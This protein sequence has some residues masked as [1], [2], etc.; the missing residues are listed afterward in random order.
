REIMT[1]G[2]TVSSPQISNLST[3]LYVLLKKDKDLGKG[4]SPLTIQYITSIFSSVDILNETFKLNESSP[5]ESSN[6]DKV[7]IG[8]VYCTIFEPGFE[9]AAKALNSSL[10][11]LVQKLASISLNKRPKN[12]IKPIL[13]CLL[14]P[15]ICFIKDFSGDEIFPQLCRIICLLSCSEHKTLVK[16]LTSVPTAGWSLPNNLDISFKDEF[17]IDSVQSL[18]NNKAALP[19]SHY[20]SLLKN[21]AEFSIGKDDDKISMDEDSDIDDCTHSLSDDSEDDS[22]Y[23]LHSECNNDFILEADRSIQDRTNQ[24]DPGPEDNF[25][26]AYISSSVEKL[27]NIKKS[28]KAKKSLVQQA[29]SNFS[30]S[31]QTTVLNF[32]QLR[33]NYKDKSTQLLY[34]ISTFQLFLTLHIKKI[35]KELYSSEKKTTKHDIYLA[36]KTPAFIQT[37]QCFHII[38]LVP[39]SAFY[40]DQINEV[41]D[42]KEDFHQY[43]MMESEIIKM[44]NSMAM[45]T[46]LQDSF[47]HAMFAGVTCPY[48]VLEV[49][50]DWLV[51]DAICQLQLKSPVDLR[52]QLKVRFVDEEGIDEGGV[53]KEFFQLLIREMFDEKYGMFYTNSES[54][55]CWFVSEPDN[56]NLYMQEMR[57]VGMILGL[58]VYNSVILN[59]HFPNALY[60]KLLRAPPNLVDL[61]SLDP[62][63]YNSLVK[64]LFSMTPEEIE[65]CYQTYEISYNHYGESKTYELIPNGSQI[66]VTHENRFDFVNR[67]VDFVFN[68]SCSSQFEVFRDGFLDIVGNSFVMNLSASELELIVCGSSDLDFEVLDNATIYDGGYDRSTPVIKYFW[69]VVKEFSVDIKKK[70]LFF[71]TGSDRVPIGGLSKMKFVIVKNGVESDRLP[72]SHT[73]FN[74][75]LLPEY[76]T[77]EK[78]KD[79][80]LTAINNAEGFGMM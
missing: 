15:A 34:L 71:T 13:V 40:N 36:I 43:K 49:R 30:C 12:M 6:L 53:Q 75:L 80:L 24:Y 39:V 23:N 51:R 26:Q 29:S 1:E 20:E 33:D 42:I 62:E 67:Y 74:V 31:N 66:A 9:E 22:I 16:N 21:I 10:V 50:R 77:Q 59:I 48:L 17:G 79:R 37:I 65:V 70:L 68:K 73:C 72:T 2:T 35:S 38:Y 32:N 4:P 69:N 58:A 55:A 46:E 56:D 63:T 44:E 8:C 14:N 47:F 19:T 60:K 52:K 5:D 27:T 18:I 25:E 28:I 64:I 45:R 41:I 61:K 78:L 54:N 11:S 76:D 57:L 3:I 7:L